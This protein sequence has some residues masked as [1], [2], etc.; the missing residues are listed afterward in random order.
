MNAN[1]RTQLK[2]IIKRAK[3]TPWPKLFHNLR[4]TRETEL[5][6]RFP[7]HVVCKWLGN[8]ARVAAQHYLQVTDAHYADA[9]ATTQNPT[10]NPTQPAA[11]ATASGEDYAHDLPTPAP[12]KPV[13]IG[14]YRK[15]ADGGGI[16]NTRSMGVT[17]LEPV[18]STV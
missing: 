13:I 12:K 2:K 18:T 17:G 1:L 10:Q 8:T 7:M 11:T 15:L 14:A 4:A 6:E 16:L 9:I 5:A 3:L